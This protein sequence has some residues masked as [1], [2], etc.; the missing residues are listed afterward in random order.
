MNV[1][2]FPFA[3]RSLEYSS[4]LLPSGLLVQLVVSMADSFPECHARPTRDGMWHFTNVPGSLPSQE[5]PAATKS[6]VYLSP[7]F[8]SEAQR[9]AREAHRSDEGAG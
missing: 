8:T 2:S 1:L 3:A 5:P 9:R 6:A 7:A 4:R